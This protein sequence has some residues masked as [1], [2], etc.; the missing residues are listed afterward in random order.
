MSPQ[1]WTE[2][3]RRLLRLVHD[4]RAL[5][6]FGFGKYPLG[7]IAALRE[8][9]SLTTN[10]TVHAAIADFEERLKEPQ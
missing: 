10:P 3:D 2:L 4:G 1:E 6:G 7:V 5:C 8:L 9:A